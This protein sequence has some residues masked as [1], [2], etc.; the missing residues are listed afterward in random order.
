M[1]LFY[2]NSSA[3]AEI[4][5]LEA[6]ISALE[7]D[8]LTDSASITRLTGELAATNEAV[9]AMTAE[10]DE[11][12]AAMTETETAA[13]KAKE[14]L[15]AADT[16]LA[17][18]NGKLA[19][20]DASVEKSAQAKFEGLGGPPLAVGSDSLADSA[21]SKTMGDFRALA[22]YARMAFI[23]NGGKLID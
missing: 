17:S 7:G 21:A 6:R 15:A 9:A 5:E 13:T 4:T 18:A 20:F 12:V 23:K 3:K 2:T 16:A 10:R 22:P 11:A 8:A 1:K 19:T 14:D